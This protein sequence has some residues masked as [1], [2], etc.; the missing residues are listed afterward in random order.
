[1]GRN[2]HYDAMVC[3]ITMIPQD[4]AYPY[5]PYRIMAIFLAE[6]H[7]GGVWILSAEDAGA[8]I[9]QDGMPSA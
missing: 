1:M 9:Q 7:D 3:S 4:T 2:G 5:Q 6:N 8:G